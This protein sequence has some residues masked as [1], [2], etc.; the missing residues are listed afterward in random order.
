MMNLLAIEIEKKY[1]NANN[2]IKLRLGLFFNDLLK[3]KTNMYLFQSSSMQKI[4]CRILESDLNKTEVWLGY[5]YDLMEELISGEYN[6][7]T[8]S[9]FLTLA[10]LSEKI[11]K[12]NFSISL[13]SEDINRWALSSQNG[14]SSTDENLAIFFTKIISKIS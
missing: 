8:S 14:T 11:S 13:N 12:G 9:L 7:D 5:I 1:D 6:K 3:K 4:L 10:N 2:D